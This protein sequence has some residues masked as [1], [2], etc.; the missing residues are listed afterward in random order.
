MTSPEYLRVNLQ[1]GMLPVTPVEHSIGL[2][3]NEDV[4]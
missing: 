1:F 3:K 2:L 4:G